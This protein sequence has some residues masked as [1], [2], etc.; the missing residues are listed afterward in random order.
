[1]RFEPI[2]IVGLGCLLPDAQDIPQFVDN[3][4]NARY[5][6]REV[7]A[8]RWDPQDYYA[9]EPQEG[10][11]YSKIGGWVRDFT[12][13][14]QHYR[15]PPATLPHIDLVQQWAIY[16]C[17]EALRDAGCWDSNS[18]FDAERC[19]VVMGN[20]MGGEYRRDSDLRVDRARYERLALEAG[21]SA[22]QTR[23]F[24]H[25]LVQDIAP[26]SEDTMPGELP[27]VVAGRVAQVLNLHG[28]N[29]ITDAA[30]ASGLAAVMNGCMLLQTGQTDW[31]VAGAADRSMDPATYAK[32]CAIGALSAEGSFPFDARASGFVMAEGTGAVVLRRLQDAV[33]D[34]ERIYGVI[35][36]LAAS[37]DGR[38]KGITAPNPRGQE[39]A[40]RQAYTMAG[41]E[42]SSIDMIEAHGTSTPVGD[43]TEVMALTKIFTPQ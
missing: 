2:A 4:R 16:V 3:L 34:R 24:A 39:L 41:Y 38:G 20:S 1:M 13:D 7:A 5:A 12:F 25:H 22:Q 33:T 8:E 19:A 14:W 43:A 23:A 28:P 30:C 27:N 37:S 15:I 26:L 21:I 36:G 17:D 40:L 42:P 35:R 6:I 11:T 32:F 18:G 10:K 31:V 29:Y 9:L